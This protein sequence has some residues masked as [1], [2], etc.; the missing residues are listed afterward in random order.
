M[1]G[2][3]YLTNKYN[4]FMSI[5]FTKSTIKKNIVL[6]LKLYKDFWTPLQPLNFT[7]FT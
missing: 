7:I 6:P 1:I 2:I 3:I 5:P 4:K